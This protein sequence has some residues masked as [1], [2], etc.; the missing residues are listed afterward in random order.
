MYWDTLVLGG[1]GILQEPV[2]QERQDAH[3]NDS[4]GAFVRTLFC[5]PERSHVAGRGTDMI[6]VW[7]R[8]SWLFGGKC[9]FVQRKFSLLRGVLRSFWIVVRKVLGKYAPIYK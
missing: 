7:T 3:C 8:K 4:K 2:P 6:S 1:T 5:K 9:G